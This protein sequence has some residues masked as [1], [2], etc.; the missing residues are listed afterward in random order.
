MPHQLRQV[1]AIN[2]VAAK[3]GLPSNV[4]SKLDVRGKVLAVGVNG[5][6]KTTFLR[7]IPLFY[8]ALPREILKGSHRGSMISYTLP[9]TSSAIVY[10]YE[11]TS[12]YDLRCAVMFRRAN[13]DEAVFYIMRS[14][15]NESFFVD[16]GDLFVDGPTFKARAEAAGVWVS[17]ALRTNQYRSVILRERTT[18]K[19][20]AKLRELAL[21]HSLAPRTLTNLGPIAA[22]ISTEK[23]NFDDLKRIV[24][25][26]VSEDS[27]D[28][29]GDHTLE[30]KPIRDDLTRWLETREHMA[31]ILGLKPQAETL[32]K[33]VQQLHQRHMELCSLHVSVKKA[34]NRCTS[35]HAELNDELARLE[36][37]S[38]ATKQ[39]LQDEISKLAETLGAARKERDDLA[40]AVRSIEDQKAHF[41]RI[42]IEELEALA[43]RKGALLDQL[44][45]AQKQL[46]G[47][48]DLAKSASTRAKER[49]QAI[50]TA[51]S[52]TM[53]KLAERKSRLQESNK[54]GLEALRLEEGRARQQLRAPAELEDLGRQQ[55][56]LERTKGGLEGQ[57]RSPQATPQ[58][59]DTLSAAELEVERAE[60][61]YRLQEGKDQ[62]ARQLLTDTQKAADVASGHLG[63]VND[64]LTRAHEKLHALQDQLTPA[65]GTLLAFLRTQD[66]SVWSEAARVIEPELLKRSDLDPG[67]EVLVSTPSHG[68]VTVGPISI[69]VLPVKVPGWVNEPELKQEL[70]RQEEALVQ[71]RA[72]LVQAQEAVAAKAKGVES[73]RNNA[74]VAGANL[75][76]AKTALEAARAQRNSLR[77]KAST[78]RND[79]AGLAREQLAE[80]TESIREVAERIKA[81][82]D[83]LISRG[84]KLDEE[85]SIRRGAINQELRTALAKLSEEEAQ[86]QSQAETDR[87]QVETD[88]KRELDG[89]GIDAAAVARLEKERDDINIQLERISSGQGD[90]KAWANFKVGRLQSLPEQKRNHGLLVSSVAE[91]EAEDRRLRGNLDDFVR[92]VSEK[93]TALTQERT[94][95]ESG[96]QMLQNLQKVSLKDFLDHVS[97]DETEARHPEVLREMVT[98]ALSQLNIESLDVQ[99]RCRTLRSELLRHDN[100]VSDWLRQKERDL[101]DPQTVLPHEMDRAK[102]EVVCQWFDPSEHGQL[103]AQLNR[104]KVAFF[105]VASGFVD[106]LSAFDDNVASFNSKLREALQK[107]PQ[108]HSIGEL[109][110]NI[111][112]G[113]SKLDYLKVLQTIKDR[114]RALSG[115]V[116]SLVADD[117]ELPGAEDTSL[118]RSYRSILQPDGGYRIH[119]REQVELEFS[120]REN[121]NRH[122]VRNAAEFAAISSNGLTALITSLF[123]MGFVQMIRNNESSPAITWPSDEIARL[124]SR[125]VASFL[126]ILTDSGIN[127]ICAE[128]NANPALARHFD[129]ITSFEDDGSV[130]TTYLSGEPA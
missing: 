37:S 64:T 85:F 18:T 49:L 71:L 77:E 118:I 67:I 113:V 117:R 114:H 36:V 75:G 94:D 72:S 46:D 25:D 13:E 60:G 98:N 23:I 47:L 10:E 110:V 33:K 63:R 16:E 51:V 41:D 124:D 20:G 30:Q 7:T 99:T 105:M 59:L 101:P 40:L 93:V 22:A 86:L 73:A 127:V 80:L 52:G 54:E 21:E 96:A 44:G 69:N 91:K 81:L 38:T 125:N 130:A 79:A 83:D 108:F 42:R 126:R 78:E 56:G 3:T 17:Q 102:A 26:R 50:D 122:K 32:K 70:A 120:L 2:I 35:R 82:K 104:Q 24:V 39:G 45:S 92:G 34:I 14:G 76:I 5:V 128:P 88:L 61:E 1:I 129:R 6:G 87:K 62:Q 65:E 111:R 48:N 109:E 95:A 116:V 89:H 100:Q 55:L 74:A 15:Y 84:S 119:L 112:S 29:T 106:A 107:I 28:A 66:E 19:D 97:A 9:T 31:T 121:N 68:R 58:T 12:E 57:I 53:V 123:L 8:G 90:L 115:T 4:I 27:G 103:L 43:S 11:R